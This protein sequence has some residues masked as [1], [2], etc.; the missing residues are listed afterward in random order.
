MEPSKTP[1]HKLLQTNCILCGFITKFQHH[2]PLS[3][4]LRHALLGFFSGQ[5]P[6]RNDAPLKNP[7]NACLTYTYPVVRTLSVYC[8]WLGHYLYNTCII[9]V[10]PCGQGIICVLPCGQDII[11]ILPVVRALPVYFSVV[12]TLSVYCLWSGHYHE[13]AVAPSLFYK[14]SD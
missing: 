4:L 8:L 7:S 3:K 14:S 2:R 11:C 12:R 9:C 13:V 10:M 6:L 1:S 5:T